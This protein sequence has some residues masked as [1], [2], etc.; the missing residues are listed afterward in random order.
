MEGYFFNPESLGE[1]VSDGV[2]LGL[3][4]VSLTR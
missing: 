4:T 3:Y 1:L 2:D